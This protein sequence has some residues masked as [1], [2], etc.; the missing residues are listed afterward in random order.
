MPVHTFGAMLMQ[1]EMGWS[2]RQL[3]EESR[4]DD[5]CKYALGV[6]R[7]V[8]GIYAVTL[9]EHRVRFMESGIIFA[10]FRDL[11]ID[12]KGKGLISEDKLQ[13]VDSFMT[14]GTVAIQDTY[15]VRCC[16][17]RLCGY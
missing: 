11:L 1:L 4:F 9:C 16:A 10:L 2:D 6:S 3:E 8:A 14:Y 15:T 17:K 5:R 12:A 7:D 13:M